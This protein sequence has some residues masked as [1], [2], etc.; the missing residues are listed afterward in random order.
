MRPEGWPNRPSRPPQP[1]KAAVNPS[2]RRPLYLRRRRIKKRKEKGCPALRAVPACLR[3]ATPFSREGRALPL[4]LRAIHPPASLRLARAFGSQKT[5]GRSAEG[6]ET[7]GLLRSRRVAAGES[8]RSNEWR[9]Q[10]RSI[11]RC[12]KVAGEI[13]CSRINGRGSQSSQRSRKGA[14]CEC[15]SA[16]AVQ[17]A[18]TRPTFINLPANICRVR[19]FGEVIL[20][21]T[22]I[23]CQNASLFVQIYLIKQL[24][25]SLRACFARIICLYH[26]IVCKNAKYKAK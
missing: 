22:I 5:K 10:M 21:F 14:K 6:A 15:L 3:Q 8:C 19:L 20:H 4:A 11:S 23:C 26:Q 25:I 13:F 9:S 16:I 2:G 18:C 17:N 12:K 1:P 7:E 24:S